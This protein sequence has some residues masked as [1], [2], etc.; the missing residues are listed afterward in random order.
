MVPGELVVT[1]E[2][3]VAPTAAASSIAAPG[4]HPAGRLRGATLVE[5]E[6]GTEDAVV[7]QLAADPRVELVE[8]NL[9]RHLAIDTNDTLWPAQDD[10][11]ES[12]G[13]TMAWDW[14]GLDG[15]GV[16]VAVI[17]TG[18]DPTHPDLAPNLAH[19]SSVVGDAGVD[20]Q[21]HGTAVAGIIGA[22][23]DNQ[24]G[25]AGVA[26]AADLLSIKAFKDD[27]ATDFTIA[28]AIHR[29][30][31]LDADVINISSG[32]RGLSGVLD[33]ALRRAD[34]R[35]ILVV[36]SAGNEW[37]A[38]PMYPAAHPSVLSVGAV[39]ADGVLAAFS[40]HGPNVDLTAPGVRLPS[41]WNR[42]RYVTNLWG[43][44]FSAP[45]AAG[46]A[47]LLLQH[48]PGAADEQVIDQLLANAGDEGAPGRDLAFGAGVVDVWTA[49]GSAPHYVAHPSPR[50]GDADD[51]P[52][53][54]R[55]IRDYRT[56]GSIGVE[57]DEDW[58]YRDTASDR[59]LQF[60]IEPPELG[61]GSLLGFDPVI[62]V[63][64]SRLRR[65]AW[66]DSHWYKRGET[67]TVRV[68]PGRTYVRVLNY[69]A[70]RSPGPYTLFTR[71]RPIGGN[72]T[73]HQSRTFWAYRVSPNDRSNV[74]DH[75]E[76][77]RAWLSP[78]AQRHV[79][80][81]RLRVRNGRTWS[82]MDSERAYIERSGVLEARPRWIGIRVSV[83]IEVVLLEPDGTSRVIDRLN[84]AS[85]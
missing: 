39:D 14:E 83:V 30:I 6:P 67:V 79:D 69:G 50:G 84:Y 38:S 55:R 58:F 35:G 74:V 70:S 65:L 57:Y 54:A 44:S 7:D 82:V 61:E 18:V 48:R 42:G 20:G 34:R 16:R 85:R 4:A 73:D 59:L 33:R 43:T 66:A 22:V 11:L 13:V 47:A 53:G 3:G 77:I 9:V 8:P 26:P 24:F 19:V 72:F 27:T 52:Y 46:A 75:R 12:M 1:W 5:V 60:R 29:A 41:V 68:P 2:D 37:T 15:S 31:A 80:R 63:Y 40:N 32:G 25:I 17:D 28:K 51:F 78:A 76:V 36:V 62:E 10:S 21:G 23:R 56:K 64:D 49:L 45:M 71:S 81:I